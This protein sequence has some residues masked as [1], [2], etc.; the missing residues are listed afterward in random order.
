MKAYKYIVFDIDDTLL[1]FGKAYE[2]AQKIIFDKLGIEYTKEYVSLDEKC[3]WDAWRESGLDDTESKDVQENYH[4]YYYDYLR[5]HYLYLTQALGITI[6]E[7]ELVESYIG[8][9]SNSKKFVE[10]KTLDTYSFLSEKYKMVLATNGLDIIQRNRISDF[11][12]YTYKIYISEKIGYIKPSRKFF[13]YV[14]EDLACEPYQCLMIGDSI[15]NDIIGA[16]SVGMD[17]C[18]Y[19]IKSKDKPESI[20]IDYEID[21]IEKLKQFLL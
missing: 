14:I 4:T 12:P 15:T 18:F 17:V 11:L 3:G 16:K 13:K 7:N 9:I 1:D 20:C 19:N 8:S 2:E 6:N 5:K 21:G 10:K